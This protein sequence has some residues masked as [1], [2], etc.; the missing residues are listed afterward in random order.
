MKKLV[1]LLF[2][3]MF[4]FT[5]S[6]TTFA[7]EATAVTID[8]YTVAADETVKVFYIDIN[9]EVTETAEDAVMVVFKATG[10]LMVNGKLFTAGT[11]G[12]VNVQLDLPVIP[13]ETSKTAEEAVDNSIFPAKRYAPAEE[14]GAEVPVSDEEIL[15]GAEDAPVVVSFWRNIWTFICSIFSFLF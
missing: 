4:I 7:A 8:G 13:V 1:A 15:V 10:D 2:A 9:G 3:V 12:K 6:I 11:N 14:K 5:M